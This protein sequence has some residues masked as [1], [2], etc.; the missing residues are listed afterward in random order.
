[1][2]KL[3]LI[4]IFLGGIS[5]ANSQELSGVW[6]SNDNPLQNS[7]RPTE[8]IASKIILDFEANIMGSINADKKRKVTSNRK[9]TK[10]KIQGVKGKLKIEN[11]SQNEMVLK[12][13]KNTSY[14]FKK[15][16][17]TH[18]LDMSEKELRDFLVDQQCDLIQGIEGQFT[19]EQFFLDKKT[20]RPLERYQFINFSER[21]NG[22]WTI[23][24]IRGNA[25]FIFEAGQNETE[26]IFQITSVKV[27]GF[28]LLPLQENNPMK[29]LTSIKT[30]L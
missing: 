2:K 20:K 3:I 5:F 25:F 18:K 7:S 22:Y 26:G 24:N 13:S 19:K 4:L 30:C 28:K 12:G 27:N 1:M 17:L 29:S 8:T 10:F 9:K 11:Y 23:K 15:L 6:L 21:S 14:I 16:D